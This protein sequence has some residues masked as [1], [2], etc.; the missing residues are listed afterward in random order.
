MKFDYLKF[1]VIV[2]QLKETQKAIEKETDHEMIK[3]E[4]A[5]YYE[6]LHKMN[7]LYKQQIERESK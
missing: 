5:I 3:K 6:L 1:T 2:N 7:A 4:L